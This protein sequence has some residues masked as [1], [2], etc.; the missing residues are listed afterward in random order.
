MSWPGSSS[1]VVLL[2]L[3][4]QC[5]VWYPAIIL[6][7][8]FTFERETPICPPVQ[9][10]TQL[11]WNWLQVIKWKKLVAKCNHFHIVVIANTAWSAADM[12]RWMPS[13]FLQLQVSML[14]AYYPLPCSLHTGKVTKQLRIL[15]NLTIFMQ[16][17]IQLLTMIFKGCLLCF[18]HGISYVFKNTSV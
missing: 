5:S 10:Y 6:I 13:H 9:Q 3:M 16:Y 7:S 8:I 18:P 14:S 4:T 17:C 11:F 1:C 15:L 12:A 2:W